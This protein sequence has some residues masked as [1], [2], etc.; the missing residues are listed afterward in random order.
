MDEKEQAAHE[1]LIAIKEEQSELGETEKAMRA[2]VAAATSD[3]N[4]L[5]IDSYNNLKEHQKEAL[6]S[7]NDMYKK[8]VEQS[9]DAFNVIEQ[10]EAISLDKMVDN[11][12]KNAQAMDDWSTNVAKLAERGVDDGLIMQLEKMGPAGAKQA[13]LLVDA[14]DEE[15]KN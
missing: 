14:T 11:L 8:L 7:M 4:Q 6:N 3:A 15:L 5:M 9:T 2:E 12:K 10:N 13:A 1:N